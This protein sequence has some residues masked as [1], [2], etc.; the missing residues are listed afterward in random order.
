MS[1]TLFSQTEIE[2]LKSQHLARIGTA[3]I[4]NEGYIQ[5]DVRPVG[6]ILTVTTFM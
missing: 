5:T 2:Y 1:N 3:A 6:L 4:S